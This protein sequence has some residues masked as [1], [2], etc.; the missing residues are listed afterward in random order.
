VVVEVKGVYVRS[1]IILYSSCDRRHLPYYL[2]LQLDRS[3]VS[4][5]SFA[6]VLFFC[7]DCLQ[8]ETL[9]EPKEIEEALIKRHQKHFGLVH[10]WAAS[11]HTAEVIIF[12][13]NDIPTVDEIQ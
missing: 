11:T 5:D 12:S 10:D 8:W 4:T 9:E 2:L 7:N 1:F 3:T 13:I 6:T